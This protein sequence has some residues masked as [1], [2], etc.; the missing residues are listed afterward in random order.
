MEFRLNCIEMV[1]PILYLF[2][3]QFHVT[4]NN[5]VKHITTFNQPITCS[6]CVLY[7]KSDVPAFKHGGVGRAARRHRQT[8]NPHTVLIW[9]LKSPFHK[10]IDSSGSRIKESWGQVPTCHPPHMWPQATGFSSRSLFLH[11]CRGHTDTL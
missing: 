4:V 7:S 3:R 10:L 2:T 11:L 6:L 8:V 1:H 9:C 5:E